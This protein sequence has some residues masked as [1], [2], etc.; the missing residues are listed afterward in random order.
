M[1]FDKIL[2]AQFTA[3]HERGLVWTETIETDDEAGV[4]PIWLPVQQGTDRILASI[5]GPTPKQLTY[6]V[7]VEGNSGLRKFISLEG[8]KQNAISVAMQIIGG[9][10]CESSRRRKLRR[11]ARIK[12]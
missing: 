1:K 12:K 4:Y 9:E 10:A 5:D 7:A 6:T 3:D 2:D 8:A 11:E